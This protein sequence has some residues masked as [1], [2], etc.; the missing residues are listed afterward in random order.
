MANVTVDDVKV[1]VH[2]VPATVTNLDP[3]I[4]AAHLL[5]EEFLLDKGMSVGRLKQIELWL[6]AHF[7]SIT[8]KNTANERADVVGEAF[9]YK[10]D[11]L[12]DSTMFGQ[13]AKLLDTSGTLA[14]LEKQAENGAS[15]ASIHWL[16]RDRE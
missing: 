3:F 5:V 7:T 13:Q 14:T 11:L 1:L 12:F 8:Y 10:V 6:A 4:D 15:F 9:Q 2:A 16:G